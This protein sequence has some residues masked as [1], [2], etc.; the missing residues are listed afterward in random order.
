MTGPYIID[1]YRPSRIHRPNI[2][3]QTSN[4]CVQSGQD[5]EMATF[6]AQCSSNSE[7]NQKSSYLSEV[8]DKMARKSPLELALE[9]PHLIKPGDFLAAQIKKM[10]FPRL[11]LELDLVCSGDGQEAMRRRLEGVYLEDLGDQWSLLWSHWQSQWQEK[12]NTV[13][14][15]DTNYNTRPCHL[16]YGRETEYKVIN[17]QCNRARFFIEVKNKDNNIKN[18]EKW[19][20]KEATRKHFYK[21]SLSNSC[22]PAQTQEIGTLQLRLRGGAG[23]SSS[24]ICDR[25]IRS[26]YRH[27]FINLRPGPK[28]QAKGNCSVE[29]SISNINGRAEIEPKVELAPD[30][31]KQVWV[32]EIQEYIEK[33]KPELI[34]DHLK[35]VSA[36]SWNRLKHENEWD[37][38]FFGEFV[39]PAIARGTKK[40]LLIFFTRVESPVPVIVV[41]PEEYGVE[42]DSDIP[43]ILAYDGSHYEG[44]IPC[45]P[46][47]VEKTKNLVREVLDQTYPYQ[48]SDI[49]RLISPWT[50]TERSKRNRQLNPE[51]YI[52]QKET[53]AEQ[54]KTNRLQNHPK[55]AKQ[56]ATIADQR[57]KN[58]LADVPKYA[59]EKATKVD[60]RKKNRLNNSPKYAKEKTTIVDQRK[61][62]KDLAFQCLLERDTGFDTNCCICLELKSKD[63]VTNIS[64]IPLAL[65]KKHC[66]KNNN[67]QNTGGEYFAC[68]D[69]RNK[70]TQKEQSM[71]T[72]KEFFKNSDFPKSLY[73]E[74]AREIGPGGTTTLNKLE[75]FILKLVIPFVRV[76]H[77]PRGPYLQVRGNLILISS[78]VS[79]SLQAIIPREQQILPVAFKRK[80][81]YDGHY[82]A[83]FID[84]KKIEIYFNWLKMNNHLYKDVD[85]STDVLDQLEDLCNEN[86]EPMLVSEKSE[87]NDEDIDDEIDDEIDHIF[88]ENVEL[89]WADGDNHEH[90][91]KVEAWQQ[92]STLFQ[93]K[94]DEDLDTKTWANRYA[95][96]IIHMEENNHILQPLEIPDN[97]FNEDNEDFHSE[98][99]VFNHKTVNDEI[100]PINNA[101]SGDIFNLDDESGLKTMNCPKENCETQLS[102]EE[103]YETVAKPQNKKSSQK[104][105]SSETVLGSEGNKGGSSLLIDINKADES[106]EKDEL[107]YTSKQKVTK[108]VSELEKISIAPGEHG[109]FQNWKQDIFI[110]EKAFPHLF[111]YGSGGYL[112]SCLSSG[113]N[114]GF[115]A[116]VRHRVRN[117]DPKYRKDHVYIFFLLLVKEHVELKNCMST[118]LRQARNT[119]GLTKNALDKARYH[120][121][122]RYSRN[123]SVFKNMRGTAPYFEAAKKNCM[124]TIRQKGAP[125]HFVT[126]SAAE[127]QW[128]GLLKSVYETVHKTVAT[129]E[130]IENMSAGEKNKLITENVVQTTL[131]FQKRVD[132]LMQKIIEPGYL[133][134]NTSTDEVMSEDIKEDRDQ[135]KSCPCYFY[136]IE[137]QARGAPHV[138]GLLWLKDKQGHSP[139]A[140][141][142]TSSDIDLE[143]KKNAIAAYHDKT[144]RCSHEDIED[145]DLREKIKRFQTHVCSFSCFKKKKTVTLKN[146][147]GHAYSLKAIRT[148]P[149]L[150]NVPICR[151][152]FPRLPMDKTIVLLALQKDEDENLIKSAKKDYLFIRYYLLRQTYD[153]SSKLYMD[154]KS[155]N[156]E[157]FLKNVGMFSQVNQHLPKEEQMEEAK[158]RYHTALRCG[159]RGQSQVFGQRNLTNLFTNNYNPKLMASHSANHDIQLCDDPYA[160]A[161]YVIGYLTKNEAGMS[162]LLKKVDEE[163]NISNMEV[164]HKMAAVLDKHREISIQECIY[165]LLGLSMTKFSV[166]VKYLNTSHPNQR[167]GLLRSNIEDLEDNE[168]VF[169]YS[170]HQYYQDRPTHWWEVR[171]GT[172]VQIDGDDDDMCLA[173]WWSYY[174]H[175][176]TGKPP[177]NA[178]LMNND[179]GYFTRRG[180]RATLRYYLN[181][182]DES[183]LARALLILFLPFRNELEELHS[184][185]PL[186]LL[187]DNKV[188]VDKNRNIFEQNNLIGDM[189]RKLEKMDNGEDDEEE[190]EQREMET[191]EQYQI[192]EHEEEFDRKKAISSLPKEDKTKNFLES[193]E[194]RRQ[195]TSLNHQQRRLFDDLIERT[196]VTEN[197]QPY[198]CYI[199]GEAGTGKSFLGQIL[200]Y[201][202]RH[203]SVKSGQDLDK[204]LVVAMAPTAKAA[205]IIRGKTIESAMR[206][207]MERYNTFSKSGN[208][209]TSQM[210][211]EFEDVK[212]I[213]CDEASMV[214]TNKLA[215]INFRM[216]EISEGQNKHQFMGGIPCIT[217]GDFRQL[218]PVLDNY[219]FEKSR[220][221]GRPSI[222]PCHWNENFRIFNLTQKM[223]CDDDIAF[224]EIC[225]R[226]GQGRDEVTEE[227]EQ[228]FLSRVRTEKIESESIHENY[229]SGRL[230]IIT[231]TNK[232][233]EEINMEKLR[234]LLPEE[235]EYVCLSQDKTT[236]RKTHI[237]LPGTV[238]YSKTQGMMSNLIIRKGAPVMLTLN[239]KTAR[240]KEDGLVNGA[241]GY[242]EYIQTA[243]GNEDQVDIIWVVFQDK[244]VGAKCYKREKFHLRPQD[245]DIDE[246]AIPIIPVKKA[247]DVT[248]TGPI[249]YVRKQFALTLCYAQTAHKCQG[250]TL[251]E[252]IIDFREDPNTT[253]P[254]VNKRYNSIFNGSFYVAITRVKKSSK[255][256]LRSFD[257]CF[258]KT[259]P[260]VEF[261]IQSMKIARPYKMMKVYI[262]E[263]VFEEGHE[264]KVGYLN[265]NGL[266][267]GFHANYLNSDHNL[268][269][270][271]YLAVSETHL[272]PNIPDE[273]VENILSNW[274]IHYRYDAPDHKPHMGIICLIPK[275]NPKANE[276][277]KP[278]TF[279]FEKNGSSQIQ[280]L[281][282]KFRKH[283]FSFVYCRSTPN[284]NECEFIREKTKDSFVLGDLNLNKQFKDQHEKILNICGKDKVMLLFENTTK[285]HNQVDHILGPGEQM[286]FTTS[287]YNFISDHKSIVLRIPLSDTH[288]IDDER[289]QQ[290][291]KMHQEEGLIK[292]SESNMDQNKKRGLGSKTKKTKNVKRPR[293]STK[294]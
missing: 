194:L 112:S 212:A 237:P 273:T 178:I 1:N 54:Q 115:S 216:Q 41:T 63:K 12:P 228:F 204:P 55:Y 277:T 96:L 98:D 166:V 246:R 33:H 199:A 165:R 77:C 46:S 24:I 232:R 173:H 45:Q 105:G 52:K 3:K 9:G 64:N 243:K 58:R 233:R 113:K 230:S 136:R 184:K 69:C 176:P 107:G 11:E 66:I 44:M 25:A 57:K 185:N 50:N 186:K 152:K 241:T 210:A 82:L 260:K 239:D 264:V 261:E 103:S 87:N 27:N 223:R 26:A 265:I 258:I 8:F 144:I 128:G 60:Q 143:E 262:D 145:E 251:D 215:A 285:N 18:I 37:V 127:Y 29:S 94:Y 36:D 73:D 119:P 86:L 171:N 213:V 118:Y 39:V 154:L 271:D 153:L 293:S 196:V 197:I 240:Y 190:E 158:H 142:N 189:I 130:I 253:G 5:L 290:F 67:T 222:A 219:I 13:K 123:F 280:V 138:H 195:I 224:A 192:H 117:A 146:T 168:Q 141:I 167:D 92:Y 249:Q 255:L 40:Q 74:V 47:D 93:N 159:I 225:D 164:I 43:V 198:Y 34:P 177:K 108:L 14:L 30:V 200:I 15:V 155:Q 287:F 147:E 35:T 181:Y 89:P 206:I 217:I 162:V 263:Q 68:K 53:I 10:A 252:V 51:N 20:E 174:T 238:S 256:W 132:K 7:A 227:D 56:K 175:Y 59:K 187:A 148:G 242:I 80:I 134:E 214:G 42:H 71:N 275:T 91:E 102:E 75:A 97:I 272:C 267:D 101:E 122:E 95:A 221:D 282:C 211:F 16:I 135:E 188:I 202:L 254:K 149:I 79:Q 62:N 32:T 218:P 49:P 114:I 78:D 84:R 88:S 235:K 289:L 294:K 191:T 284:T 201:A 17:Y 179:K 205:Y 270:L 38:D 129:D 207:N 231:A 70:M 104:L 160:V 150:E 83:E 126:L 4:W 81:S 193:E 124:A 76:A 229:T 247:F 268:L 22:K 140:I 100:L 170:P 257:R 2:L 106:I 182:D 248:Q 274:S 19:K 137:F 116:Y 151:F 183:L 125:T 286:V 157:T 139:L 276:F 279:L 291:H 281:S 131:H 226:V 121:L 161:Q 111:P 234:E 172:L 259:D 209:R 61:K 169:H 250:S 31:A 278:A 269:K 99:I 120:S 180:V 236:N 48:K 133:D 292:M 85:F 288:F 283:S 245:I 109:E 65:V 266:L 23:G 6:S 208:E 72:N 203:V 21:Y 110:E 220:L 163:K 156:F 90:P 244:D 28:N